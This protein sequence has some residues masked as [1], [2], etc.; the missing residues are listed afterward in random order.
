[1]FV[2]CTGAAKAN[3]GSGSNGDVSKPAPQR[4]QP[5]TNV[6]PQQV[7]TT[8]TSS[9]SMMGGPGVQ[10]QAT[11]LMT[12]MP[13]GRVQATTVNGA[14]QVNTQMLSGS[15]AAGAFAPM[16]PPMPMMAPMQWWGP[17]GRKLAQWWGGGYGGRSSRYG[18]RYGG[19]GGNPY[20]G[21]GGGG[22]A[23][24]SQSQA[25]VRLVVCR[26]RI[27]CFLLPVGGTHSFWLARVCTHKRNAMLILLHS[28]RHRVAREDLVVAPCHRRRP[29]YASNAC[30]S[31]ETRVDSTGV[32]AGS[33]ACCLVHCKYG[34]AFLPPTLLYCRLS[35]RAWVECL[36]LSHRRR[37]WLVAWEAFPSL[38]HRHSHSPCLA[39]GAAACCQSA[40]HLWT[41]TA[42]YLVARLCKARSGVAMEAGTRRHPAPMPAR[43]RPPLPWADGAAAA[44]K[45]AP[46]PGLVLLVVAGAVSLCP[47]DF[48]HLFTFH[49][50]SHAVP[51]TMHNLT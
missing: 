49:L 38:A 30:P 27:A 29:R 26:L 4:Q 3:S 18:G 46:T 16:Q 39:V 33:R 48:R 41:A 8:T 34:L 12:M 31:N 9:S 7:V 44:A 47:H 35:P 50:L 10:Q 6:P 24:M 23:S 25:Q 21:W 19:W 45:L 40:H 5:S 28:L 37:P 1:M 14:G 51:L 43:A 13:D 15:A 11:T 32:A 20:G 42:S 22:G 2:P 36:S 17:P